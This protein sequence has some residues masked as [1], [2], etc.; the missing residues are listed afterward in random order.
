[1]A[2]DNL[3]NNDADSQVIP[4]IEIINALY[5]WVKTT[6]EQP[7][8][9]FSGVTLTDANADATETVTITVGDGGDT[10][11]LTGEGLLGGEGG[12][13]TLE[14]SAAEVTSKLQN[15]VFKPV[16]GKPLT[17]T[18]TVFTLTAQNSAGDAPVSV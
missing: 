12:V 14:G 4:T 11:T 6:S 15:L 13:Y 18:G 8:K 3:D 1:M 9:P 5:F 10:G 17:T 7:V 16:E 2:L